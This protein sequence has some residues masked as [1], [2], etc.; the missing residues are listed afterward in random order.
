MSMKVGMH[1]DEQFLVCSACLPSRV[2]EGV[3]AIA[4]SCV[5]TLLRRALCGYAGARGACYR[6]L[7]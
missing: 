4:S 3:V 5:A 7:V 2:V 6:V 1:F